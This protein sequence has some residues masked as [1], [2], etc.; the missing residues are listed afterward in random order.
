MA[1]QSGWPLIVRLA[2]VS[3]KGMARLPGLPITQVVG[4]V[5]GQIAK[6]SP[7]ASTVRPAIF[8]RFP[9]GAI[10]DR[11]PEAFLINIIHQR[12]LILVSPRGQRSLP[13]MLAFIR[14]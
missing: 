11:A 9:L 13:S 8:G 7:W 12:H 3:R 1:V 14:C 5:L 2:D 6:P 10:Y 4:P